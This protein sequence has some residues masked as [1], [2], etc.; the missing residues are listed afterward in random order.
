MLRKPQALDCPRG[1]AAMTIDQR[2]RLSPQSVGRGN[3]GQTSF[4]ELAKFLAV[5]Y[6]HR[7][8]GI[9]QPLRDLGEVSGAG[10]E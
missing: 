4:D 3:V 8:V 5:F 2:S 9:D 10:S 1:G 6:S 7:T